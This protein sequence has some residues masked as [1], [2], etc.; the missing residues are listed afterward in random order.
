MNGIWVPR[1]VKAPIELNVIGSDWL[2]EWDRVQN[3]VIEAIQSDQQQL[4]D[5]NSSVAQRVS[6]RR[7]SLAS[8]LNRQ[9]FKIRKT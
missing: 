5:A 4:K 3:N 9:K 7:R 2:L 8:E 6:E 1:T